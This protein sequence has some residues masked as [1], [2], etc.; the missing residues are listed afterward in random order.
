MRKTLH[1]F[2]VNAILFGGGFCGLAVMNQ[3]ALTE[4]AA[5]Y[6]QAREQQREEGRR[7]IIN[8]LKEQQKVAGCN[9]P[10]NEG[11]LDGKFFV[12]EA[13]PKG[14]PKAEVVSFDDAI[15]MSKS[16]TYWVWGSCK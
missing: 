4:R 7:Y 3:M 8:T 12:V 5:E 1:I 14:W 2:A 16:K 15:A 11:T 13:N 10:V 9:N 6:A